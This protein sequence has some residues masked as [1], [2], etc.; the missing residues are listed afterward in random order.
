MVNF[1]PLSRS[2]ETVLSAYLLKINWVDILILIILLR[3]SYV[4]FTRGLSHELLTLAGVITAI[5]VAIHNYKYLGSFFN[6]QFKLPFEFSNFIGFILLVLIVFIIIRFIRLFLYTIVK[7]ELFPPLERYG[8]LVLGVTRGCLVTSLLLLC[9]LFIPNQYVRSSIYS[10]SLVGQ[11]FLKIAP[12]F[13]ERTVSVFPKYRDAKQAKVIE[14]ILTRD[15]GQ[16]P[17]SQLKRRKLKYW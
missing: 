1:V 5:I 11:A 10:N 14:E 6:N 2:E 7:L 8:G 4:G 3:T 9:L 17:K 12:M 16:K 13:Y 15:S